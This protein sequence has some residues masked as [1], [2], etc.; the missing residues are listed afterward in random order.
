MLCFDLVLIKSHIPIIS[1]KAIPVNTDQ[2]VHVI[3]IYKY[4]YGY[5]ISFK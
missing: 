5:K 1:F 3:K 4:G 2:I